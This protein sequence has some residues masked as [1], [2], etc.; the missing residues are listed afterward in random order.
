MKKKSIREYVSE[1]EL[2]FELYIQKYSRYLKNIE[3]KTP[4]EIIQE[5]ESL[6]VKHLAKIERDLE[7]SKNN[8]QALLH[9]KEY[10]LSQKPMLNKE[11]VILEFETHRESFMNFVQNSDRQNSDFLYN[12]AKNVKLNSKVSKERFGQMLLLIIR[13]MGTMPSFGG[14]TDNWKTDF[15]SNAVEHTLLYAHNYD[16]NLLSKRTGEKSKAF[17][18]ITQVCYNAFIA[19]INE[20]KKDSSMIDE[21]ISYET[22]FIENVKNTDVH[23]SKIEEKYVKYEVNCSS[24]DEIYKAIDYIQ[25]SNLRLKNLKHFNSLSEED[26]EYFKGNIELLEPKEYTDIIIYK[27]FNL[28]LDFKINRTSNLSINIR[29][30]FKEIKVKEVI[31][32]EEDEW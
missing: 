17:A 16:E 9:N 25:E 7:D 19:V 11:D 24:I 26:R 2:R 10:I 14:Y 5:F 18:Y 22:Y 32:Q 4:E 13:N 30:G 12:Y 8:I 31:A 29:S 28:P 3:E 1:E 15:Y 27:D 21:T 6:K 20:R 23:E